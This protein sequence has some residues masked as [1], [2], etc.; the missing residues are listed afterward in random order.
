MDSTTAGPLVS[1]RTVLKG[2]GLSAAGGTV[3]TVTQDRSRHAGATPS[4]TFYVSPTGADSNNGTRTAPFATLEAARDAI[5]ALKSR[6]RLPAGG[7][8]VYLRGG[9]HERSSTFTLGTRDSGAEGAPIVYRGY[10][11]EAVEIVGSKA[12]DG[13]AF[14]MEDN[15]VTASTAI[16]L[17]NIDGSRHYLRSDSAILANIADFAVIPAGLVGRFSNDAVFHRLADLVAAFKGT[18]DIGEGTS[19]RLY[20]ILNDIRNALARDNRRAA[21]TALARFV[22][23]SQNAAA[24]QTCSQSAAAGL[25]PLA[26]SLLA[27]VSGDS[28]QDVTAHA[29]KSA[30]AIGD[31]LK[32]WAMGDM[33]SGRYVNVFPA[34]TLTSL[35]PRVAKTGSGDT[36]TALT[37]GLAR[38]SVRARHGGMTH[39]GIVQVPVR[40]ALLATITATAGTHLLTVGGD[41][42]TLAVTGAL[43]N[44]DPAD[45]APA[46][47]RFSTSD[48]TVATVDQAG[49]VTPVAKGVAVITATAVQDGISA[50]ATWGI[51]VAS[52]QANIPEGWSVTNLGHTVHGG[53][54]PTQGAATWEN[55][56]WWVAGDG[57]NIWND[58]DDC[59]F[60]H[61][62]I[63]EAPDVTVS[64][65]FQSGTAGQYAGFGLLV[66]DGDSDSA[67]EVNWR[68]QQG[69]SLVLQY[70]NADHPNSWYMAFPSAAFPVQ[71]RLAKQ[72][73][74]FTAYLGQGGAWTKMG[75][76]TVP[77]GPDLRVGIGIFADAAL[78]AEAHCADVV[79]TRP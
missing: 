12:L 21:A 16:G 51:I 14:S 50:D 67:N 10:H 9:R 68:T 1:R 29:T 36:A 62:N 25:V 54:V 74:V 20:K 22:A 4:L 70:R 39:T 52:A 11:G 17:V 46:D 5:R 15:W 71:L 64:A 41:Q 49:T 60:L 24:H 72:G 44:G 45:I 6:S 76:V 58:T 78:V 53:T 47:L 2:A 34:H 38:L 48:P 57:A 73:D 7:V 55:G 3:P 79:M 13:K 33:L 59:T 30:I 23:V 32:V 26:G 40:T 66:R 19:R 63:S 69:G 31:S 56:V 8:T 61:Q 65:T 37:A 35:N 28:F 43:T 18:G 27:S 75:S 77:M 42:L